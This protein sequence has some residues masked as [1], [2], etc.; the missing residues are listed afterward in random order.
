MD[1]S[2][3]KV[4]VMGLKA[5]GISACALLNKLGA[6]VVCYDD[7]NSLDVENATNVTN[8]PRTELFKD[9]YAIIVSP[10]ISNKHEIIVLA[11]KY[12]VPIFSELEM[13]SRYLNAPIIAVTG[14]NGKTTTVNML[15]K[16]LSS[17]GLRVKAMGN[18]GYPVSQVVLDGAALDWA[19][20]ETSSFQLEHIAEF[21]PRIAVVMNLAPDH[22][23]RYDSYTD[24]VNAKKNIVKNMDGQD[25][26]YL[27]DDDAGTK[28]FAALTEAKAV[29]VSARRKNTEVYVQ[30]NYFMVNDVSLCH[31]RECKLRGEHNKY[32]LLIALNIAYSLGANKE[33]LANLIKD[34]C[35]LPNRIEY[36]GTINGKSYYNDSKGTNIHACR[37]AIASVDGSVGLI[38]GG[39]DKNEDF[40]EFFEN[41]DDKVKS[42]A[43]TGANADKIYDAAMKMGF[44]DIVKT[45]SLEDAVN[46][47]DGTDGIET[48]LFS[49]CSA[50][51]DRYKNYSERGDKFKELVYGI[52]IR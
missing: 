24:Y 35:V 41:I 23:D 8:Y 13:G 12:N 46:L 27:N 19:I 7:N 37:Y 22:L 29:Y 25:T 3:K 31:V 4:L 30:D 18:I 15:E 45:L 50:S 36:V 44:C 2:G 43:V 21:K 11:K 26:L 52:K 40:C 14:T 16:V 20:I 9:L 39:S 5:S 49:P 34:Y 33:Q 10:S 47:L 48:V 17:I 28:E 6:K 1:Y 32:N 42:I 51:F 38:L